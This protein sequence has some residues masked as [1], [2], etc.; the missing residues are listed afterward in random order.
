MHPDRWVFPP[1]SKATVSPLAQALPLGLCKGTVK[2]SRQ[3]EMLQRGCQRQQEVSLTDWGY[4][5]TGMSYSKKQVPN[6]GLSEVRWANHRCDK[7]AQIGVRIGPMLMASHTETLSAVC[8]GNH[9]SPIDSRHKRLVMRGFDILFSFGARPKTCLKNIRV[10]ADLRRHGA[11]MTSLLFSTAQKTTQNT[12]HVTA[13]TGAIFQRNPQA[14]GL[15][16][17]WRVCLPQ[18]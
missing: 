3:Q 12:G 11:H 4:W 13:K 17:Y 7:G 6:K 10:D 14:I 2:E 15:F 16:L 9:H 1:F 8:E 5:S 18:P